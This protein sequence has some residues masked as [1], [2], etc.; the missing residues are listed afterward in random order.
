MDVV[1]KT[2]NPDLAFARPGFLLSTISSIMFN[3]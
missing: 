3:F 2:E 1:L